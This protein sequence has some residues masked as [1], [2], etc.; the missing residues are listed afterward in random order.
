ME[1]IAIPMEDDLL[2][3][4][5]HPF[6]ADSSCGCHEDETLIQE[7]AAQVEGGALTPQQATDLVAGNRR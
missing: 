1:P 2:H 6:C 3:T 7:V 5:D 4:S